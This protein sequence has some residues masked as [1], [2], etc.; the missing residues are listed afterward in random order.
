MRWN[1]PPFLFFTLYRVDVTPFAKW[2]QNMIL[3]YI[4]HFLQQLTTGVVCNISRHE[5]LLF[6]NHRSGHAFLLLCLSTYHAPPDFTIFC[7]YGISVNLFIWVPSVKR[8]KLY[9]CSV[10]TIFLS[11]RVVQHKYW[12]LAISLHRGINIVTVVL[13]LIVTF[14]L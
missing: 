6:L 4:I 12:N 7:K 8:K 1:Q 9:T 10:S 5:K 14:V 11:L 13:P 3:L 2:Q